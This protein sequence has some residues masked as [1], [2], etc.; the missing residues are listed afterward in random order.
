MNPFRYLATTAIL[1]VLVIATCNAQS[2]TPKSPVVDGDT[3]TIDGSICWHD[4]N[5]ASK[6]A[7]GSTLSL[8]GIY[9]NGG[10]RDSIKIKMPPGTHTLT[11]LGFP[12][13][14]EGSTRKAVTQQVTVGA[15]T[16]KSILVDTYRMLE[17]GKNL[18]R[19]ANEKIDTLAPTRAE[20]IE[21]L[22]FLA[23]GGNQ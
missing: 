3:V 22:Q 10:G 4:A 8:P 7:Q 20:V 12:D 17:Q 23:S 2:H 15:P 1:W 6:I 18:W 13:N 21:A 14:P 11:V 19:E 9:A 16:R 5:I